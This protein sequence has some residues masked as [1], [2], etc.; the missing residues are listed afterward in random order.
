MFTQ[1]DVANAATR[2]WDVI[3]AGSSFS[4]MFFMHGLPKDARVLIV[5]RGP[6]VPHEQ[7]T[8]DRKHFHETFEM[9]NT[10][11]HKKKWVALS[12]F[13]GNSNC[14]WGQTPRFHPNDFQMSELYGVGEKWPISYDEIEPYYGEVEALMEI[15]GGSSQHILPR[16]TPFPYPNHPVSRSDA[17]CIEKRP[18]IWVP[19]PTARSNGGSRAQCCANGVC[20]ICPVDSKFTILNSIETFATDN[21]S[22]LTS[23][24]ARSVIVE[25]GR[26][27]GLV[28]Q[29]Q[30]GTR[31]ELR[32]NLVALAANAI[33][34]TTILMRSGVQS[35]A[36][37]KYLHE[38]S[39]LILWADV[40]APGYFGGSS[41]T[42]HCYGFYD[43]PHRSEAAAVLVENFNAPNSLRSLKGRWTERMQLKLIAEDL[44]QAENFVTLGEN[45]EAKI[46]WTGHSNY[47][48][49]G[50][51]RAVNNLADIL[52]F[53]LE[54]IAKTTRSETEAHIQGTH[55]MGDD[56][57]NSVVDKT[58][59]VYGVDNLFAL[60]SGVFPTSSASNPTLTL[61]ALSLFA[62][63]SV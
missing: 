18:D 53:E 3:I 38:Q 52:P 63:R 5:E 2:T 48:E 44:P 32:G 11:D 60:G 33:S 55:R 51:Q 16:S 19:V 54:A 56:R 36:L 37:G 15:A 13:G 9:T 46:T 34:N 28:V 49:A 30:D 8:A 17:I 35:N 7:Q 21:V 59:R 43:G 22:L 40:A 58:S 6:I 61:S 20:T 26:A 57:E 10:S 31:T 62:G 12:M 1:T 25:G 41:I 29:D 23:V 14:W 47:S 50:L 42:G 39:S 4:A 24:E 27:T 45:D